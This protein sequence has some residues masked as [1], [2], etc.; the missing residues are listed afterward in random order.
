[1][2]RP[3]LLVLGVGLVIGGLG[4]SVYVGKARLDQ[5]HIRKEADSVTWQLAMKVASCGEPLPIS[6]RPVPS[7]VP[8]PDGYESTGDD[9]LQ[10]AFDCN[11]SPVLLPKRFHSSYQWVR[12][13]STSGRV[14]AAADFDG[15]G[16]LDRVESAV[17]C[18]AGSCSADPPMLMP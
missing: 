9:W 7:A 2:R 1:M 6:S 17:T 15:D 12:D 13:S 4:V 3:G 8:G 11:R 16:G 14:V 10:P 5:K 18:V